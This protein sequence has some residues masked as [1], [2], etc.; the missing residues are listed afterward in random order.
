[1]D[2][3]QELLRINIRRLRAFRGLT[4]A[5]LAELSNVSTNYIAEIEGGRR[6]PSFETIDAFCNAF[7]VRPYELFLASADSVLLGEAEPRYALRA[8]L[9]QAITRSIDEELKA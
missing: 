6:T 7:A 1:M 5:R 4:Q 9:L 3:A 8:R 2:S